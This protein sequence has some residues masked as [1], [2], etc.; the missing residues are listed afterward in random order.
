MCPK[1][2]YIQ[3]NE[4][5]AGSEGKHS[6]HC[7]HKNSS[8]VAF[9]I[10]VCFSRRMLAFRMLL[11]LYSSVS[12]LSRDAELL[13]GQLLRGCFQE[14]CI[15]KSLLFLCPSHHI[16]QCLSEC[17]S[18]GFFFFSFLPS[19]TLADCLLDSTLFFNQKTR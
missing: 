1:V 14:H 15:L 16:S 13:S 18:F 6:S 7:R 12:L 11:T 3:H 4:S 17:M 10:R 19:W 2:L 8:H 9:Y 5:D